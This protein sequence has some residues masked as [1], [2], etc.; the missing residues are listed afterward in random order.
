[1]AGPVIEN[2]SSIP[3]LQGVQ[4][5]LVD[6]TLRPVQLARVLGFGSAIAIVV[7]GVI[8]SGIFVKPGL[9]A[10]QLGSFPLVVTVSIAGWIFSVSWVASAS[11]S[12]PR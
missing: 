7:G 10:N 1:M 3:P 8:G 11:P 2:E 5:S 6:D 4:H 12:S 9:V